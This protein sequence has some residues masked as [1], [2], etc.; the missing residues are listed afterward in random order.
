MENNAALTADNWQGVTKEIDSTKW[1]KCEN[2]T[3]GV[4]VDGVLKSNNEY[5]EDYPISTDTAQEAYN[6][7]LQ[8]A[9]ASYNRDNTDKRVVDDVK[10]VLYLQ[11]IKVE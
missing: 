8:E 5:I 11:V 7:V 10:M 2:I 4:V 3:D 6:R 1:N 9:G